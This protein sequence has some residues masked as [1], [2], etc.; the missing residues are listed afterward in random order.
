M[1]D[2][3][4]A[5][6]PAPPLRCLQLALPPYR[7]IPGKHPHPSKDQDGHQHLIPPVSPSVEWAK[8]ETNEAWL[9]GLD[10]FDYRYYWE[11]HEQLEPI[12][13]MIPQEDPHRDFV[14]GIIQAAAFRLKWHM[15]HTSPAMKLKE[16]ATRRL[17]NSRDQ[18]GGCIWGVD[19]DSL[20]LQMRQVVKKGGW[21][22]LTS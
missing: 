10:L 5:P 7:F 11:A 6:H 9:R 19:I 14:Q 22:T 8:W 3:I 2:D 15:G 4:P 1:I 16:T 20:T 12:W 18:L 21:L 17:L 13:L